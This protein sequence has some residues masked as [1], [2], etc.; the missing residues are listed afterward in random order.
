MEHIEIII[1]LALLPLYIFIVLSVHEAGHYLAARYFGIGI[2]E[3]SLGY[4][5]VLWQRRDVHGTLWC[6]RLY[7]ICAHVSVSGP[8]KFKDKELV[9]FAQAPLF[10]RFVTVIAGPAINI[11]FAFCILFAFHASVGQPIREPVLMGV[12]PDWVADKAGLEYGDRFLEIDGHKIT[13]HKQAWDMTTGN[14]GKSINVVVERADGD[15]YK[16]NLVPTRIKYVDPRGLYKNHGRIGVLM[17]RVFVKL[18]ILQKLNEIEI[19]GDEDAARRAVLSHIGQEVVL[20]L[21]TTDGKVRSYRT[22]LEPQINDHLKDPA[23]RDYDSFYIGSIEQHHYL[24]HDL[25]GSLEVT[26]SEVGRLMGN[27]LRLPF[28]LLPLDREKIQPWAVVGGED[29]FLLRKTYEF[30]FRLVLVSI[31]IAFINL[32]PFP[33]MDGSVLLQLYLEK[34]KGYKDPARSK[35]YKYILLITLS[36]LYISVIMSNMSDLPRYMMFKF[37]KAVERRGR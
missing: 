35:S 37:E 22:R 32:V 1:N 31:F 5:R 33:G 15:I 2:N 21:K 30:T 24:K 19:D 36:V 29:Q 26:I 16:T 18:D 25:Q 27:L 7:P 10:H 17:G 3:V 9:T 13:R 4:G 14:P 12:E 8:K 23:H 34:Y 20:A 28:Q 11:I 6:I